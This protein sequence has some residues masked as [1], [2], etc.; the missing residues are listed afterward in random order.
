VH[1]K[2][3][4]QPT[5]LKAF[6]KALKVDFEKGKSPYNP[7]FIAKIEASKKQVKKGNLLHST[8]INRYGK[9]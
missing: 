9:I 1:P 6:A 4:E 2:N 7:D 8:R 3:S 5:A